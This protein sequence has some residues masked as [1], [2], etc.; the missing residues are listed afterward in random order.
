MTNAAAVRTF[1]TGFLT[2]EDSSLDHDAL[3]KLMKQRGRAC[4]RSLEFRQKLIADSNGSMDKLVELMG[5][6]VGEENCRRKGD[7]V[8]LIYPAGKC[9]CDANPKRPVSPTDPYCDCSAAN[10][11]LLFE[12]VGGKP[13]SVKVAE[14][15]RR[16]GS[17][18][19]FLINLA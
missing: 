7:I 2:E 10:N 18:C 1:L 9:I 3:L 13:V 19:T 16:G 14:S 4:C 11:Q 15:P 8:T 6:I 17:H 12:T 5:K